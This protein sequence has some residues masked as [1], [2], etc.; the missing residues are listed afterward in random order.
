M[1]ENYDDIINLPH[2]VSKTRPQMSESDR[3]AQFS[4]FA[5]LTGHDAAISETARLTDEKTELDESEKYILDIKQQLLSAS[6]ADEPEITVTYF[7]PDGRK[8]GGS[9][10][11]VM[12]NLKKTDG[13][14]H[15]LTL[16]NGTVIK[17]DDI[18]ALDSPLFGAFMTGE[19]QN[20]I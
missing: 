17:T 13:V 20:T 10:V 7:V 1:K 8:K 19:M 9:Y 3:A 18:I 11:T 12:G 5:A 16:Q 2:H 4:P 14:S 6:I 15:T